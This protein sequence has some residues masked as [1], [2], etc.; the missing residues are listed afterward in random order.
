MTFDARA[1]DTPSFESAPCAIA[2]TVQPWLFIASPIMR[3]SDAGPCYTTA[4]PKCWAL[5][6]ARMP[7]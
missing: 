4:E 2:S 3:A 1:A 6:G 7:M 5:S